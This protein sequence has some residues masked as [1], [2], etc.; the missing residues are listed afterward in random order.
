MN[1]RLNKWLIITLIGVLVVLLGAAAFFLFADEAAFVRDGTISEASSGQMV[2]ALTFDDGPSAEWTPKLLDELKAFNVKATF[3]VLG[4]HVRNNPELTKRIARE[5]HEIENHSYRHPLLALHSVKD[6]EKEIRDCEI[7]VRNL[8]GI[9]TK[10]FRPPRAWLTGRQKA[11]VEK[12]GYRVV[13]WSLNSKDWV[14]FDDKYLVAH[15]LRNVRPGNI[16]LFHD[17]GGIFGTEGRNR[18]ETVRTIAQLIPKMRKRGYRFV[19]VAELLAESQN[20]V[21]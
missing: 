21:R 20:T 6:L 13:L 17:G 15:V 1:Q 7:E 9:T 10:Y 5:G 14:T 4:S 18:D 2:V 16:I 19:T 11:A 12:M 8:T 3:F